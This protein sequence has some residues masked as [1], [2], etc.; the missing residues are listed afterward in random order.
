[1][2]W[3]WVSA[4]SMGKGYATKEA[5]GS[6]Y[7]LPAL[8]SVLLFVFLMLMLLLVLLGKDGLPGVP[9][10][11]VVSVKE[12][13]EPRYG[14]GSVGVVGGDWWGVMKDESRLND[15]GTLMRS[16]RSLEEPLEPR[17][18]LLGLGSGSSMLSDRRF[19]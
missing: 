9:D 1:M 19:W 6:R 16:L 12:P 14:R 8:I 13:T 4:R 2:I 10:V 7:V 11:L 5:E 15:L 18:L 3:R 17:Y